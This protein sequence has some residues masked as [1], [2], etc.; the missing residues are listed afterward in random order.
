MLRR[1]VLRERWPKTILWR[2][3]QQRKDGLERKKKK[4]KTKAPFPPFVRSHHMKHTLTFYLALVV[5]SLTVSAPAQAQ[6]A[7]SPAAPQGATQQEM[8]TLKE[9]IKADAEKMK[10]AQGEI[11]AIREK[12]KPTAER[13]KANREKMKAL[14]EKAKESRQTNREQIK[15]KIQDK[16]QEKTGATP[17]PVT[18]PAP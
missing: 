2:V 3:K 4:D 9:S 7:A 14:R 8:T 5:L 16:L 15:A 17:A 12:N 11:K 6:N 18:A 10:A 1:I 13:L